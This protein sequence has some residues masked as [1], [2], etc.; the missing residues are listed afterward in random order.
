MVTKSLDRTR[1]KRDGPETCIRLWYGPRRLVL[2]GT[3]VSTIS[4]SPMSMSLQAHFIPSS[5]SHCLPV[6]RSR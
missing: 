2:T 6:V 5:S 1:I 3:R 4:S